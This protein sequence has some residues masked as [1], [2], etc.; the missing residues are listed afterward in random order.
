MFMRLYKWHVSLI[1]DTKKYKTNKC[2]LC[3]AV[4]ERVTFLRIVYMFHK[5]QLLTMFLVH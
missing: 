1:V 3:L 2:Y 4:R 5:L